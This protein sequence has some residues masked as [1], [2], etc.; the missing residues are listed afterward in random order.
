[1][2]HSKKVL[3]G[4]LGVLGLVVLGL[5]GWIEAGWDHKV[6]DVRGPELPS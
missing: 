5:V 2:R 4:F 6:R 1:M 3:L